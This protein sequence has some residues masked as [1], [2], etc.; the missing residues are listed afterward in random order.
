MRLYGKA[1][2]ILSI[3]LIIST[4]GYSADKIYTWKMGTIVNDPAVQVRGNSIGKS[5]QLFVDL[6][7]EK[8]NGQ[9][10]IKPFYGEVLGG[11]VELFEQL[12]MGQLE[13]FYGQPMASAD[14]RFGA[15]NIPYLFEDYEEV[16]RIVGDQEGDF[17]KLSQEWVKDSNGHLLAMAGGIVRGLGNNKKNIKGIDDLKGMKLR[18]YQD[19]IV[20]IFWN[21]I[22]ITQPLPYTEMYSALQTK[23]V[24][25]VDGPV[26]MFLGSIGELTKYY[27]NID[28]QWTNG[29]SLIVNEKTWRELPENLQKLVHEAAIEATQFQGDRETEYTE[30]AYEYLIKE[31]GYEIILLT[32]EEKQEWI[33]Y[34]R[35]LDEEIKDFIGKETFEDTMNAIQTGRNKIYR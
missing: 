5:M 1:I 14:P 30:E 24:D 8:T 34:A 25:A 2:I 33:D 20:S 12:N 11:E 9:V 35:T 7:K 27:T 15:W 10:I 22:V 19:P 21:K 28:W 29:A 16:K 23:T 18:I 6:V 4:A 31:R 26:S 3:L 13:V 32:S 17:F